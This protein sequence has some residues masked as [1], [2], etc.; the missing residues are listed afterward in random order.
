VTVRWPG[1]WLFPSFCCRF[2]LSQPIIDSSDSGALIDRP[3][4][5]VNATPYELCQDYRHC[6]PLTHIS[7]FQHMCLPFPETMTVVC[8]LLTNFNEA[9]CETDLKRNCA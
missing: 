2:N 8:P 5:E 3:D 9:H 4:S 7:H 1:I 6:P